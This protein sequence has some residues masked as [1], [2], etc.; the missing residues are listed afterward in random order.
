[1]FFHFEFVISLEAFYHSFPLLLL[2]LLPGL[3]FFVEALVPTHVIE[4]T[5]HSICRFV[6]CCSSLAFFFFNFASGVCIADVQFLLQL[7]AILSCNITCWTQHTFA[8]FF[9]FFSFVQFWY[10]RSYF[11][12]FGCKITGFNLGMP[13]VLILQG[14]PKRPL[15]PHRVPPEK[16]RFVRRREC[17]GSSACRLGDIDNLC[18]GL[19]QVSCLLYPQQV[20]CFS[21]VRSLYCGHNKENDSCIKNYLNY[22]QKGKRLKCVVSFLLKF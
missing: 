17:P 16:L 1:M 15:S 2:I 6:G 7:A 4:E 12:L 10:K 22:Y 21:G 19:N 9:I 11:S 8:C 5:D 14:S 13:Q 3:F 18:L 20:N